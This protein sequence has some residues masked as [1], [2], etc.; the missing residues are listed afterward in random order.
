MGTKEATNIEKTMV[1][2]N[3]EY[4]TSSLPSENTDGSSVIWSSSN[5]DVATVNPHSGL[6]MAQ[7]A[8]TAEITATSQ[9]NGAV[10][11]TYRLIVGED[12][13]VTSVTF[14][15]DDDVHL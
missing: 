14:D 4:L 3:A 5:P 12:P 1:A 6:V 8:G 11:G 10:A 7:N 9:N 15:E 13:K 2:G